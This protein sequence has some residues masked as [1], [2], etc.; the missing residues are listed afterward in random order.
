MT[1]STADNTIV[2]T[3][4]KTL[5]DEI[6]GLKSAMTAMS[7]GMSAFSD[8]MVK[9]LT[10]QQTTTPAKRRG[11][12]TNAEIAAE[13]AASAPKDEPLHPTAAAIADIV[14][15]EK[16]VTQTEVANQ[17]KVERSLVQNHVNTL[18]EKGLIKVMQVKKPGSHR[19]NVFYRPDRVSAIG[20]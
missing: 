4:I 20:E 6:S 10:G 5:K 18:L 1:E 12:R 9:F 17:L 15:R 11:R 2:S 16:R 14:K 3:E 13:R 7:D 19:E 8:G